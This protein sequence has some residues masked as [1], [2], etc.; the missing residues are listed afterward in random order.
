MQQYELSV[1]A[2]CFN[3]S[4]NVIA[5]VDRLLKTFEKK[6][7]SAEVILVN[8]AS[9]DETGQIIDQLANVHPNVVAIH[10]PVNRGIAAAWES[11][12]T[13]AKGRYVC[14]IDADLQNLPEDVWRLY[15]EATFTNTDV[16]S[17]WRSHVSR[18]EGVRSFVS[19]ALNHLLNILFGLRLRDGKSGFVLARIEV[20]RDILRHRYTYHHPQTFITIAAHAKGYSIRQIETLFDERKLG[21]SFLVGTSFVVA[22]W[23][24]FEDILKGFFEFRLFSPYDS[25]LRHYLRQRDVKAAPQTSLAWWRRVLFSLYKHSFPIHHWM[26]SKYAI[27]YYH[28][29][30]QSQWMS[31]EN[32]KDYQEQRLRQLITHAYHKVPF[33]REM[34]Q[35]I[36]LTPDDIRTIEDLSK[37]PV[38]DK[39]VVRENIYLGLMANDH[40]KRLLQKVTTSGSTGEPFFTYLEK[41]QVEMRWAATQRSVE[42]TGYQFGDRQLRLWH[43]HLGMNWRQILRETADAKLTRRKFIPAYEMDEQGLHVFVNSIDRKKPIFMDGYAESFNFLAR[44]L[45]HQHY[46]GFRPKAIMSSAQM[47]PDE[48]RRIIEENFGCNVYD[49]YGAREFGGGLAYQCEAQEGY[50]VVSECAII[51]IVKDGKTVAPGET[52]EV[53]ITELNNF[54]VPLIRYRVGDLAVQ[55]DPHQPCR[56]GRGLPRIG[57]IQGRIQS[58]IIGTNN[59]FVPGSFFA[60]LFADYD[61]AITQFQVCQSEVGKLVFKIVKADLFTS[62]ILD[63]VF[64]E[65]RKHLGKDLDIQVEFVDRV[66]MGR[67]GKRQHSLSTVDVN[68]ILDRIR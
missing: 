24:T 66:A 36:G 50:H 30:S 40:D 57:K 28:D 43:K 11:G 49:K 56:C 41:R 9:R 2:P 48:S 52:G 39:H 4:E 44:Y 27:N 15:Q 32:M 19:K 7:M 33:Y 10:H 34:F 8:D 12:V 25:I 6:R 53:V 29:L 45:K 61:Y 65:T 26:I 63:G 13:V 55:M 54:S 21:S 51:E 16:V 59:Q 20:M 60:R 23:R 14:F 18:K 62:S 17:G 22:S 31:L 38:I 35:R 1:I 68:S 3:E 58:M 64:E 5:L 67:T 46:N 37:L 47:L 42:W